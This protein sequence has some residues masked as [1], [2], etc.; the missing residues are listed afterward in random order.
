MYLALA[1]NIDPKKFFFLPVPYI[2][3]LSKLA[4]LSLEIIEVVMNNLLV[5]IFHCGVFLLI[6]DNESIVS[7]IEVLQIF[8]RLNEPYA[9]VERIHKQMCGIV[10]LNNFTSVTY[11]LSEEVLIHYHVFNSQV[12]NL[13]YHSFIAKEIEVSSFKLSKVLI[14]FIKCLFLYELW[15]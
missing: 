7:L 8:E 5:L 12:Q 6:K 11:Y 1:H 10:L 14:V 4:I 15:I 2:L 13:I 9:F 3:S